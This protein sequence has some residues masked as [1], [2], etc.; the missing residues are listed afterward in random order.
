[1]VLPPGAPPVLT[2]VAQRFT[3]STRGIV[4]FRVRRV[5]DV[6]AGPMSRHEDFTLDEVYEDGATVRVRVVSDVVDGKPTSPSAQAALAAS[7]EHPKPGDAFAPPFDQNNFSAYQYQN[8]GPQRIAFT[9][10]VRDQGHGNGSFT[11]DGANNVVTFTYQPNVLPPHARSGS[12]TDRRSEVLPGYWA[13]TE[14][15]Q[16][17]KGSY[18]IFSAGATVEFTYSNFRRFASLQ[19]AIESISEP[20][21][22][23]AKP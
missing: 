17:Y 5:F 10:S 12:V 4:S 9:S 7:Y 18:A 11:Y 3:E 15:T 22:E 2:L 6:H 19:N 23:Q 14:E 1:M 16:E 20:P 13:I 8:A 21:T